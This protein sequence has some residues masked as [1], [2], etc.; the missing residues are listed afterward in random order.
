MCVIT[1]IAQ[2]YLVR[3]LKGGNVSNVDCKS[4]GKLTVNITEATCFALLGMVETTGPV[5]SNIALVS[6]EPGSTLCAYSQPHRWK[7]TS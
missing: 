1:L 6:T 4:S 7:S 2:G 3:Y 5:N